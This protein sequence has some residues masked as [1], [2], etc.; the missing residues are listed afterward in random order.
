MPMSFATV[1]QYV[2]DCA[3]CSKIRAIPTDPATMLRALP[4][5]HARA[6][7]HGDVLTFVTDINGDRYIFFF[8]NATTRY[9]VLIAAPDKIPA[10]CATALMQYAAEV[11]ILEIF[12]SDNRP[13]YTAEVT[14]ELARILG[15]T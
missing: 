13:E 11:G 14:Q 3:E 10:S 15:S 1:Q 4:V 7:T 8:I 9:M 12:W 2:Q 6:T 5:Y